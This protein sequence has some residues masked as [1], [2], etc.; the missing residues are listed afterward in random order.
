MINK[1]PHVTE[2]PQRPPTA[3]QK[4]ADPLRSA[5]KL[6]RRRLPYTPDM[7]KFINHGKKVGN[8]EFRPSP[9][10]LAPPHP[11][12]MLIFTFSNLFGG[13]IFDPI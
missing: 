1:F 6:P 11:L 4:P 5:G 7:G 8:L 2:G 13:A 3:V 10:A 9:H 12:T